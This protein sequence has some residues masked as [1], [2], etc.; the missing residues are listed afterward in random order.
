MKVSYLLNILVG[1]VC[2]ID[3]LPVGEVGKKVPISLPPLLCYGRCHGWHRAEM[4]RGK[5][6]CG[7]V[8]Y[9]VLVNKPGAPAEIT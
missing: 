3:Q 2:N 7:C 6:S 5:R 1:G 9:C 4:E 8:V